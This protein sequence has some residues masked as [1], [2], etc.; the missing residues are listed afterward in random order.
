VTFT[1]TVQ[2]ATPK[3]KLA[4]L[5]LTLLA[6]LVTLPPHWLA[7]GTPEMLKPACS[8]SVKPK[9]SCAGLPAPLLMVKLNTLTAPGAMETGLKA[10]SKA[11]PTTVRL[12]VLLT[13]PALPVSVLLTPPLVLAYAPS[14]VL[15]TLTL[16]VQLPPAAKLPPLKE[17]ALP[18]AAAVT[19]PPV[20]VVLA[21]GA[22]LLNKLS[23]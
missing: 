1:F 19:V 15:V 18:L 13:L 8:V 5:K 7:A 3:A 22:L 16:T 14:T 23:G 6:V 2:L 12:A 9:P 20:H 17:T 4:L 10:F 11:V 21:V